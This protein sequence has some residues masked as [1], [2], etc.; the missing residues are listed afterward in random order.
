MTTIVDS[1]VLGL[2]GAAP[3]VVAASITYDR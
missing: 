3:L 2:S 1:I